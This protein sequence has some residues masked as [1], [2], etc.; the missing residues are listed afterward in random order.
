MCHSL[1]HIPANTWASRCPTSCGTSRT[2]LDRRL[3]ERDRVAGMREHGPVNGAQNGRHSA[4]LAMPVEPI[5]I[6]CGPRPGGWDAVCRKR[7][8]SRN[9]VSGD[10]VSARG[11]GFVSSR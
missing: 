9:L 11:F 2:L 5:T 10:L 3:E 7:V 4:T 8:P 1:W 6:V